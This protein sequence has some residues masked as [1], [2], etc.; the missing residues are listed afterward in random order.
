MTAATKPRANTSSG[1]A[2]RPRPDERPAAAFSSS[3]FT[4]YRQA[5]PLVW[6]EL[7]EHDAP[8]LSVADIHAAVGYWARQTVRYVLWHFE[9]DGFA[10]STTAPIRQGTECKLFRKAPPIEIDDCSAAYGEEARS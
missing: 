7:P 6:A 8:P 3:A 2:P 9:Q 10:V 4:R 5:A 1:H